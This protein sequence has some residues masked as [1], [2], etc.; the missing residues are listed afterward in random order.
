MC[1]STPLYSCYDDRSAHSDRPTAS[2]N[3][4]KQYSGADTVQDLCLEIN[5]HSFEKF[6]KADGISQQPE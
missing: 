5:M 2:Q 4:E 3:E 6:R 1:Q